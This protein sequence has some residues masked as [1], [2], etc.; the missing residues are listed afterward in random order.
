[1]NIL[2]VE[3]QKE[4]E[5]YIIYPTVCHNSSADKA[6][7]KLYYYKNSKHFYCYTE[8]GSMSLSDFMEHYY[9]TRGIVYDWYKD[10]FLVLKQLSWTMES[11]ETAD[12]YYSDLYKYQPITTKQLP[13]FSENVLASFS[14]HYP[15]EW[16]RENITKKSMDK[17][18]ILFSINQNKIV[19]PHYD[20]NGM[21]IGIRGRALDEEEIEKC[22]KYR[23]MVVEGVQYNHQLSQNLYGLH[24]NKKE[25]NDM[26]YCVIFEGE[27]SV[28]QADSFG[29]GLALACCG[30]SFNKFQLKLLL[31][32]CPN[33]KEIIIGFDNEEE[34]HKDAYF[35]K[36]KAMCSKYTGYCKM[37]FIYDRNNLTP[38]K[39]SPTDCGRDIYLELLHNRVRL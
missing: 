28:L 30:S 17:Y 8:C 29:N 22:G 16:L 13:I 26:G 11:T 24:L 33:L 2:G 21:L 12:K 23:P 38:K 20:V 6:S 31:M 9:Q 4:T 37:S 36:L 25:I 39:A 35:I 7:A 27:K 1:M 18:N 14:K 5:E 34:P 3:P 19:I 32:T 15:L 10:I